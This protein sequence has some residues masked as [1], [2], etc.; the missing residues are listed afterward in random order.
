[1]P[2]STSATAAATMIRLRTELTVVLGS[3]IMKKTNSWYI[4]PDVPA[5][6][7]LHDHGSQDHRELG[8]EPDHGGGRRRA[9]GSGHPA[10]RRFSRRGAR[11]A[12]SGPA[13]PRARP[14]GTP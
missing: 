8:A 12:L 2:A 6:R 4:G 10:G 5:V 3:V 1:M 13:D 9:G 14:L 7:L 11:V